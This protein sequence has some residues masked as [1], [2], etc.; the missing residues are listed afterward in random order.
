MI[1]H[2]AIV[3]LLHQANAELSTGDIRHVPIEALLGRLPISLDPTPLRALVS[4]RRVLVTG[5]GG[6]V[7]SELSRQVA[8]LGP[9][10]LVMLDRYE[11]NLHAVAMQLEARA[12]ARPVIAD[13][14][15]VARLRAVF[16]QTRPHLVLHAAAHKHLP[17]MEANPCEA[18][19]NNVTGTRLVAEAAGESGAERFVLIS[20]DKAVRPSSVMG[21]TKRVA[22][23]IV[24]L[25]AAR[26]Q[27]EYVT[28]RFGNVL[29]SNGSVL[30]RFIEQINAGGPLTVTHPEVRRYFMLV[31]EAVQLVLH[32]ATLGGHSRVCVL[33]LDDQIRVVDLARR[34]SWLAGFS[35]VEMPIAF[36][37][38]R[39][40]EK[41]SE[42]LIAEDEEADA[43]P[44][45]GIV[46]VRTRHATPA[47][48]LAASI[49]ELEA[50]AQQGTED[51]V[52]ARL[53]EILP[54]F[55]RA[56]AVEAV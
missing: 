5:A 1:R 3:G 37:G 34:L 25:L 21:A 49:G 28:V 29:G 4:G 53:Q 46:T 11:N 45:R 13:I 8:S 32:A 50:V 51:A 52:L 24:N 31:S 26:Y 20:T 41:M 39:P 36:I 48:A 42:E 23:L 27:T 12:F 56:Q 55:T 44:I 18:V 22:E 10:R 40:G 17:L 35:E 6:S 33:D 7:G 16:E 2:Q 15:D 14:T 19:K 54:A 43:S 30:P 47:T 38:L 9:E